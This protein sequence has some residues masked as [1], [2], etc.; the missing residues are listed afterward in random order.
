MRNGKLDHYSKVRKSVC[1]WMVMLVFLL[2]AACDKP[3]LDKLAASDTIVAFGDSLTAGKG[4]GLDKAYPAVLEELTGFRVINAG[5][6]GETT[7]EGLRRFADTLTEHDADLV[8]LFEGGNDILRNQDLGET[9]DNLDAM[10][11][12]AKAQKIQIVLVG[13][14]LKSLFSSTAEFYKEL[15]DKHKLPLQDSIVA[16]LIKKPSMKSDSVHFNEAGYRALA[17]AINELLQ[18]AGALAR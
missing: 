12:Y 10:I 16:S 11:A 4:V 8:I 3:Q 15:A 18:D 2:L 17:V 9:R 13:L 6:S 1:L 7:A 5:I 14:P